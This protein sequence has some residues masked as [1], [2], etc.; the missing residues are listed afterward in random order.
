MGSGKKLNASPTR[1]SPERSRT[2]QNS[3]ERS[4]SAPTKSNHSL[5]ETEDQSDEVHTS[6]TFL[7]CYFEHALKQSVTAG[8]FTCDAAGIL[9]HF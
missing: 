2:V 4:H 6:T 7:M 8:H 9:G 3:P 5:T 1:V